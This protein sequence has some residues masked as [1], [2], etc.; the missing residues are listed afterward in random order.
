MK[1]T[2]DATTSKFLQGL[3]ESTVLLTAQFHH[4]GRTATG[5]TCLQGNEELVNL[6]A[7]LVE[8]LDQECRLLRIKVGGEDLIVIRRVLPLAT[9]RS[10]RRQNACC[11]ETFAFLCAL[12]VCG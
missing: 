10:I 3:G 1:S 12:A 2:S 7:L 4:C 5:I 6:G 11:G 9:R 8:L